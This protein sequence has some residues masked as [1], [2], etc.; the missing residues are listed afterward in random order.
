MSQVETVR[1]TLTGRRI[2]G[3]VIRAHVEWVREYFGER[4]MTR[5]LG[6][7]PP[8][9]AVEANGAVDSGWCGFETLD[10]LDR[11][12][13]EVCGGRDA[14]IARELGRYTAHVALSERRHSLRRE[15]VHRHCR[16]SLVRDALLQNAGFRSYEEVS[17]RHGR[18]LIRDSCS[19]SPVYCVGLAGYYQQILTAHGA[20][21]VEVTETFCQCAG[22]A[23]CILELH[24]R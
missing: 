4:V 5:V 18:I 11:A 8:H 17:E 9:V 23:A 12:I 21:D 7:L 2:Q 10:L 13:V 6:V 22:D 20:T 19:V 14:R 3:L 16:C 24:W 15:D 1:E